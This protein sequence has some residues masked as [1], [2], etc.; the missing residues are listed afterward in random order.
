MVI[1]II[2]IL[3]SLGVG[4]MAQAQNDAAVAATRSRMNIIQKI[5]EIEL[6]DYE[7]RRSPISFANIGGLI[8]VSGLEPKTEVLLHARNLKRMIIADLIRAELPDGSI[9]GSG[10]RLSDFPSEV[11]IRYM[12]QELGISPALL[13]SALPTRLPSVVR[14]DA[15]TPPI[16][17]SDAS[18]TIL[19]DGADRAEILYKILLDIDVDGAP[20]VELLGSSAIGDSDGDG[21]LE[22]LDA[23]GEPLFLEWQQERL[24]HVD[25]PEENIW[26][27]STTTPSFCGLSCEHGSFGISP[28]N[29]RH[30]CQP[31]LPTQIRPR[32][33]SERIFNIDGNLPDYAPRGG[34]H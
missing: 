14:W 28:A 27:P 2:S 9:T 15:W 26:G 34:N 18:D 23:W 24:Q 22:I 25:G 33:V 5:L 32:L 20:A 7:V 3:A 1:V 6:E 12:D 8:S 16:V 29:L 21:V 10:S 17:D 11:L 13:R 30:Y 19:E 31:V 4:V